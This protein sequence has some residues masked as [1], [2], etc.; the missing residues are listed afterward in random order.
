MIP[1]SSCGVSVCPRLARLGERPQDGPRRPAI[2][3]AYGL[4]R[5]R[6]ARAELAQAVQRLALDLAAALL[7][8]AEG[9]ADLLVGL[10]AVGDEAVAPDYDLAVA[11]RQQG[12]RGEQLAAR[13]V[14]L[15]LAAD[16]RRRLVGDQLA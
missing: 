3:G 1:P 10:N 8:D 9:R 15:G 11:L 13:L 16:V 7:A 14:L 5:A 6:H 4:R 2:H 12:E